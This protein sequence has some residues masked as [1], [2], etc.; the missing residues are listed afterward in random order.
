M[1]SSSSQGLG[2]GPL[3]VAA[4]LRE[5]GVLDQEYPPGEDRAMAKRTLYLFSRNRS[6]RTIRPQVQEILAAG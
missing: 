4:K 5:Q 1:A 3:S 2:K 6:N